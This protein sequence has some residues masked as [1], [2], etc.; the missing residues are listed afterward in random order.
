MKLRGP[1]IGKALGLLRLLPPGTEEDE[2][3]AVESGDLGPM[4]TSPVWIKAS[5]EDC[6]EDWSSSDDNL[7]PSLEVYDGYVD[8]TEA[9]KPN[10][11][12]VVEIVKVISTRQASNRR[13]SPQGENDMTRV[14]REA[15]SHT[16]T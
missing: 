15:T 2:A 7:E 1:G 6:I 12:G 3:E 5:Y 9:S 8:E 11:K 4:A 16:S 13:R 14:Y 10:G